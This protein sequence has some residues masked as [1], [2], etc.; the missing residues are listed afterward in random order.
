MLCEKCGTELGADEKF[1]P[2]CG[3]HAPS[4]APK[5]DIPLPPV[6]D[7]PDE[8]AQFDPA[9]IAANKT[10]AGLAYILFFLPLIACPN[11]RYARFHANQSL[12][13]VITSILASILYSVLSALLLSISWRLTF[14]TVLLSFLLFLPLGIFGL[15]GL[16]RGFSGKAKPLPLI[17]KIRILR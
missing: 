11:S 6:L 8:S 13:L 9:D 14:V 3:A 12:V 16:I 2:K 10:M 17:G 1:C 7:T 4:S 5:D 15:I